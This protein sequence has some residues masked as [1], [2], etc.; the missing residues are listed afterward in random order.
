MGQV[1]IISAAEAEKRKAAKTATYNLK[2]A[3]RPL[4]E[5]E[6]EAEQKA[7]SFPIHKYPKIKPIP[8]TLAYMFRNIK[9]GNESIIEFMRNA[10]SS[11]NAKFLKN[12]LIL[13]NNMDE[14]SRKRIDIFDTLC[15]KYGVPNKK[16][17][18]VVQEGMFDYNDQLTQAALMGHKPEFVDLLRRMAAKERNAADRRLLAEALQLTAKQE[19]LIK[20]EDKSVHTTNNLNLN[21]VPS[22]VSSV[23]KTSMP[24]LP[25]R[26]AL[27]EGKQDYIDADFY[28]ENTKTE[29]DKEVVSIEHLERE[30]REGAQEL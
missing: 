13:W 23:R 17:W 1:Q 3:D 5:E 30:L 29:E 9:G 12:F 25:D 19:P 7:E 24:D 20:V 22:F 15:R 26:K 6:E 8:G 21:Q 11:N 18:G 2:D 27:T 4:S 16:F 10:A 14:Y 28:V